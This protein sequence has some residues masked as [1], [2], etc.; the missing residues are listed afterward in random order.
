[1]VN[2]VAVAA[3]YAMNVHRATCKRVAIIDFD[4]HHGNGTEVGGPFTFFLSSSTWPTNVHL[5]L[6]KKVCINHLQSSAELSDTVTLPMGGTIKISQPA[7]KP[8]YVYTCVLPSR[9]AR[10]TFH[11][12]KTLKKIRLGQSDFENV[13]FCSVHGFGKAVPGMEASLREEMPPFYPASGASTG[14]ASGSVLNYGQ[15]SGSRQEWR[16]AWSTIVLPRVIAFAPDL[17]LVS[18]GFDAHAKVYCAPPFG[19]R[20]LHA[21]IV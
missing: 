20:L 1:M 17:I 11:Y 18:A 19:K 9:H 15:E 7:Y 12:K 8:W 16:Q 14:W 21:L 2:N 5:S 6:A 3:A 4:V 13:L 10:L